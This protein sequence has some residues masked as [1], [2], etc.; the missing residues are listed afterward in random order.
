MQCEPCG[1]SFEE[2]SQSDEDE[3]DAQSENETVVENQA[4]AKSENPELDID[5]TVGDGR[6]GKPKKKKEIAD[7]EG[8]CSGTWYTTPEATKTVKF[9]GVNAHCCTRRRTK[10]DA[11]SENIIQCAARNKPPPCQ[12]LSLEFERDIRN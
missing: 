7:E 12:N 8:I 3:A 4:D 5:I 1:N 2:Q 11:K 6:L 9:F 10:A